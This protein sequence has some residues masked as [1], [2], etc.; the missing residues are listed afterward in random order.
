MPPEELEDQVGDYED[1][2]C[3]EQASDDLEEDE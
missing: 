2:D 1:E 3:D